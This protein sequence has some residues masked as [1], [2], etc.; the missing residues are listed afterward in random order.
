MIGEIVGAGIDAFSANSANRDAKKMAREQMKF[1][2][3]MSNTAHQREVK[4]LIAAGLNPILSA[5][6]GGSSTPSGATYTPQV[7]KVGDTIA[8]GVSNA[9]QA[10]NLSQQAKLND[11][12]IGLM[13]QQGDAAS[14]S[15][16]AARAQ[17]GKT[18]AETGLITGTSTSKISQAEAD[19][20]YAINSLLKLDQEIKN[21]T[22]AG[23]GMKL[24]NEF[25]EMLNELYPYMKGAAIG[26]SVLTAV[27]T[28][29][30]LGAAAR[31][32]V[33]NAIKDK[34]LKS[35]F[36]KKGPIPIYR[37]NSE[38]LYNSN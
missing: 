21:A 19:A 30:A 26:G 8:K 2:E 36:D 7:A 22:T 35:K 15:A 6:G 3:R 24:K 25:Q 4:D 18:N 37:K 33:I 20:K 17:A 1:Q 11:A 28:G 12:Q 13:Q 16:E 9:L 32:K 34:A 27:G 14:A 10:R 29:A 31:R 5:G 23:E 38:S